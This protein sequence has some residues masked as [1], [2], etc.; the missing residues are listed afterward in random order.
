MTPQETRGGCHGA[1]G[2]SWA[3]FNQAATCSPTGGTGE[4]TGRVKVTKLVG[5]HEEG[6]K[7]KVKATHTSRAEHEIHSLLPLSH[8]QESR[9]PSHMTVRGETNVTVNIPPP[10]PS[11]RRCTE[12]DMR[13]GVS[14]WSPGLRCPGSAPSQPLVTLPGNSQFFNHHRVYIGSSSQP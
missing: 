6:L 1:P 4:R 9:A 3:R 10:P 8:L 5:C 13:C 11:P 14:P 12:Y 2:H 7:D